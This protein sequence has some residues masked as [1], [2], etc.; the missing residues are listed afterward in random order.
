MKKYLLAMLLVLPAYTY[1]GGMGWN[2]D[3]GLR[4]SSSTDEAAGDGSESSVKDIQVRAALG[5][6]GSWEK[7]AWGAQIR[8]QG[9]GLNSYWTDVGADDHPV[10]ISEAWFRYS[11]GM[12]EMSGSAA[13]TLGRHKPIFHAGKGQLVLDSDVRLDGLGLNLAFG[14]LGI[15]ISHYFLSATEETEGD[16][17]TLSREFFLTVQPSFKWRLGNDTM[18]KLSVGFHRVRVLTDI[19]N[20][21][22]EK[23]N[24]WQG[25][26]ALHFPN[27]IKVEGE[28]LK[29]S[30]IELEDDDDKSDVSYSGTISYGSIKKAHDFIIAGMYQ[31]KGENAALTDFTY[32]KWAPGNK[33]FGVGLKYALA[34]GLHL[35]AKYLSLEEDVDEDADKNKYL[36]LAAVAAF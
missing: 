5:V 11:T 19:P 12:G 4:Y 33:G 10:G 17:K 28:Y 3:F 8:T 32:S 34:K 26:L 16:D 21:I 27:M 35:K 6:S 25:L 9:D 31:K 36:E 1:A 24:Y 13:V 14:E 29:N 30:T 22:D 18:A 15:N 2:G 23:T 20:N 7:V